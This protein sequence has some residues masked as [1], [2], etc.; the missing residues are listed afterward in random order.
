MHRPVSLSIRFRVAPSPDSTCSARYASPGRPVP[1]TFG[2]AGRPVLRLPLVPVLWLCRR[3][4][5]ESPRIPDA[6]ALRRLLSSRLPRLLRLCPA[7]DEFSGFP[8]PSPPALPAMDRRVASIL[9]SFGGAGCESLESPRCFAPPVSP[10]ISA[11]GFPKACIFRPRLILFP[12]SPRFT[13]HPVSPS[14][15]LRVAPNLRL[16]SAAGLT[17]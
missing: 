5:F 2:L 11:P 17:S 13:H 14:S 8:S 10:T 1:R 6:S 16:W 7:S 9:A 15:N 12:G 4:V 3:S